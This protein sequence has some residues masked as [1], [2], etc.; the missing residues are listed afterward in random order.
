MDIV[1]F[2]VCGQILYCSPPSESER[3]QHCLKIVR[4]LYLVVE[5]MVVDT[6]PLSP[7]S[8]SLS[9]SLSDS[10]FSTIIF[11]EYSNHSFNR[12]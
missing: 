9:L 6:L 12:A 1:V 2:V 7:L 3:S 8:F 4:E 11:S 10:P 5:T